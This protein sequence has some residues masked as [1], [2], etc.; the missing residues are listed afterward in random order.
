PDAPAPP[1][2][3]SGE[4]GDAP[5]EVFVA[6]GAFVMGTDT[7]PWAYDNERPAHVVDVDAFWIDA[8]PVTNAAYAEFVV[9]GGYDDRRWW[10]DDGWEWRSS[11]RLGHPGFWRR[12]GASSWSRRRF[13]RD[14]P[15]PSAE[16]VQHVCWYEA[17]AYA[18]WRGRR[19][20]TE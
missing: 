14:E 15:L 19:L 2:D 20:P 10:C 8:A 18:R 13:G 5:D 7:E 11:A 1:H 4:A 6:G 16:P 9:A 3:A 12:E 17:D